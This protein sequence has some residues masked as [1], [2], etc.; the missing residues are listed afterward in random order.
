MYLK[1]EKLAMLLA[2]CITKEIV[3]AKLMVSAEED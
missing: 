3:S 1:E 2:D